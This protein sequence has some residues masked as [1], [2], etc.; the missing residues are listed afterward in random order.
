MD[1]H[2]GKAIM[3]GP[4]NYMGAQY[5]AVPVGITVEGANILTRSLM[6]FGQGAIRAHPY[7]LKEIL[8][9]GEDDGDK[10]LTDFD[11][12]FW[13]HVA[14]ALRNGL[15]ATARAWTDGALSPAPHA[16]RASHRQLGRY[17]AAFA[18]TSDIALLTLGGALKRKEMLSARLGDILSE[19]YFLSGALKRWEDEG[20]QDDDFPLLRWCAETTFATIEQRF[21]EVFANLPNRLAGWLL[22]AAVLPFG[23]RRRGPPDHVT[24]ACADL[25]LHPSPTRERLVE[26]V[27][28]GGKDGAIGQLIDAF[29]RVVATQPIHDRLK[30]HGVRE[31]KDG[32]DKG[33]LTPE[34]TSALAAADAAVAKVIAVDDFA[35][36]ALSLPLAKVA[37]PSVQTKR[38][39]TPAI[40]EPTV[41]REPRGFGDETPPLG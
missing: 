35:P 23:A 36:E 31:W 21:D 29:E 3:E 13:A 17:S 10:G 16:G 1:V 26:G 39:R 24:R 7:V 9:L 34:E 19:M 18:L 30:D 28:V 14:H 15:K 4:R 41:D 6:V 12:A 27:Y 8:A 20:R 33:L 2:G 22:R 5:R 11:E 38:S 32:L 25:L 37:E 40:A